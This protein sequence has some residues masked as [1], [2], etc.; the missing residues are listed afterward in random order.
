MAEDY[1]EKAGQKLTN[2]I[3]NATRHYW[4][5]GIPK[6]VMVDS[7][8]KGPVYGMTFGLQGVLERSFSHRIRHF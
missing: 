1:P 5:S 7:Q 4:F 8:S 3:A 6:T 2:G